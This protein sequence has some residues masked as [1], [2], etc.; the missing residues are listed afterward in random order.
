MTTVRSRVRTAF[1]LTPCLWLAISAGWAFAPGAPATRALAAGCDL[2]S[3]GFAG[4]GYRDLTGADVDSLRLGDT[5]GLITSR[6]IGRKPN[7]EPIRCI[8]E[9]LDAHNASRRPHE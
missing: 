4:F 7:P 2:K 8:T 6:T 5:Q 3:R 1:A 9:W